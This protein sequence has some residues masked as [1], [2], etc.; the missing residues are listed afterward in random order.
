MKPYLLPF[1][2]LVSLSPATWGCASA[3]RLAE[4]DFADR[5]LAAV[6]TTPPRP[7]IEVP[8]LGRAAGGEGGLLGAV[9]RVGAELAR[10][11]EA[12]KAGPKLERAA[13]LADVSGRLSDGVLERSALLLR[14]NPVQS[15]RDADFEMVVEVSEYGIDFSDW[16]GAARW[17]IQAEVTLNDREGARIWR[18]EVNERED[19]REGVGG[20]AVGDILTARALAT[21]TEEEMAEALRGLADYSAERIAR[22]LRQGLEKARGG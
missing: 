14:A 18:A 12:W 5:S 22:K 4:Y 21:M 11:Y 1:L 10:D 19:V 7:S 9:I 3:R 6:T 15:V 16:D 13:A 2:L 17:F 8:D 20:G